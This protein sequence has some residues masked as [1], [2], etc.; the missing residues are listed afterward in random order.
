MARLKINFIFPFRWVKEDRKFLKKNLEKMIP[1]SKNQ[2]TSHPLLMADQPQV[3]G[4]QVRLKQHSFQPKPYKMT[5][6]EMTELLKDVFPGATC[7]YFEKFFVQKQ[8]DQGLPVMEMEI[9][10]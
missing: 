3:V 6:E 10:Y 8:F 2:N 5:K 9:Y 4:Y 7:A 1:M